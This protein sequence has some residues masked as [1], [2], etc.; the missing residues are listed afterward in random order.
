MSSISNAL[1][2]L[3]RMGCR[4]RLWIQ[5]PIGK[6]KR[7]R[8]SVQVWEYINIFVGAFIKRSRN[9]WDTYFRIMCKGW[10]ICDLLGNQG[11]KKHIL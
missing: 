8:L 9:M 6:K 7:L 2:P 10:M 1:P 5:P 3:I 11:I 4:V